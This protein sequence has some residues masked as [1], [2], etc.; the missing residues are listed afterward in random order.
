MRVKM[1]DTTAEL[2]RIA[3]LEHERYMKACQELL[4]GNPYDGDWLEQLHA[5]TEKADTAMKAS[6]ADVD[7]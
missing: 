7:D 2:T 5:A 3:G 1:T 6:W 4:N